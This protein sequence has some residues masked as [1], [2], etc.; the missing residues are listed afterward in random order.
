MADVNEK[1]LVDRFLQMVQIDSPSSHER[2]MADYLKKELASLGF[3]VAEDDAGRDLLQTLGDMRG[4]ET[5]RFAGNL[6]A[7]KKGTVQEASPVLFA[8]HMD[9]VVSNKGVKASI[10]D[11]VIRTDGR[12]I[13]G[14]D[15]KAGIAALLEVAQIIQE[16]RL[17]H[18]DLEF[19]FTIAEETG[20]NGARLL[21]KKNLR[22]KFGFVMD[23]GGPPNV[24]IGA[25]PTEID[26]S[27]KIYGKAAH[28]GV[29]P[30]DGVSA[31]AAAGHGLS[32][33]QMG[34]IDEETTVNIGVIKGGE[35]TNIVCDYVELWGE[36]R[37]RN[38]EK[39][40]WEIAKIQ[41]AFAMACEKVGA[42]FEMEEQQ[43]YSG[44][45]L[46]ESDEVVQIAFEGARKAGMN[47]QLAPRGGGSDTNIFNAAGIPCVNLGVG[48]SKDH[49]VEESVSVK[50]LVQASQLVLGIVETVVERAGAEVHR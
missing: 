39:L 10:Q 35:K 38:K 36:V 2:E 40:S 30:E 41:T 14:A 47:P 28:S 21:D 43:I 22:A 6:I 48:A 42:R 17:P 13:L 33:V 24:V 31:I 11:G 46:T 25:S 34:R 50:D 26:F 5:I 12:T 7:R 8:A 1:R 15:D 9:T 4:A 49:T 27:I 16:N 29:N 44:F 37:S 3:E 32:K 23:S 45:Q 20:L 19:V 18:G